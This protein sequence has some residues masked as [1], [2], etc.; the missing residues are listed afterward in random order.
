MPNAFSPWPAVFKILTV[1]ALLQSPN[2][3]SL[4]RLKANSTMS[5]YKRSKKP[6]Q[7]HTSK[8]QCWDK[9]KIL[10]FISNGEEWSNRKEK[11]H[12]SKPNLTRANI[13]SYRTLSASGLPGAWKPHPHCFAGSSSLASL[14]NWVCMVP[15]ASLSRHSLLLTC[16][17]SSW[18][19]FCSFGFTHSCNTSP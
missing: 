16:P 1:L 5:P 14:M 10:I 9:H 17:L 3:K 15:A 13:K 7:L 12:Q 11:L 19:L 18:H 8:I 6:H 4:L 2:P